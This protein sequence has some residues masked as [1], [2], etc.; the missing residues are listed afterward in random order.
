[1]NDITVTDWVGY[2]AMVLVISSFVFKDILK[3]RMVNLIGAIAFISYG[4][5]L[6]AWPIIITNSIIIF[7]QVYY[8]LKPKMVTNEQIID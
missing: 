6:D 3:L 8:L 7:I 5:L 1:M 2:L 4:I